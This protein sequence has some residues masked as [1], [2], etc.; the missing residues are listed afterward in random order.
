EGALRWD[1]RVT[2]PI[3]GFQLNAPGAAQQVTLRDVLSHRV[4]LPFHTF[5]RDLEANKP[6]PILALKL[7]ETPLRCQPGACY[8]YQNV[9][10]GPVSDLLFATTADFYTHQVEARTFHPLGM[11]NSTFGRDGRESSRRWARPHVRTKR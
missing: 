2:D 5:D 9:A 1:T 10:F 11:Q 4:G 6:Y 7:G 8:A 3:P